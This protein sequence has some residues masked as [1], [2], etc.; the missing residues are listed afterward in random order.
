M[1]ASSMA[2]QRKFRRGNQV[3]IYAWY[4][5]EFGYCCQVIR[6]VQKWAGIKYPLIPFD[7][8]KTGF[9]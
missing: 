3:Q 4:D 1:H 5:N 8:E 7:V 2:M 9:G 6:V